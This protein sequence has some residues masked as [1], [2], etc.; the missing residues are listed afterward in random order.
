MARFDPGTRVGAIIGAKDGV[1]R[2]A[3]FGVYVGDETPTEAVGFIAE[4]CR[5]AG[6]PSPKIELDSGEVIYGCECWWG[7]EDAVR[8]DVCRYQNDGYRIEHVSIDALRAHL[9][10]GDDG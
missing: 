5:E 8:D 9:A 2:F 6:F 10:G 7:A 1:V 3:G 4:A